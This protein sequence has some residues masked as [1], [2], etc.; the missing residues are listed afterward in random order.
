MDPGA[1]F[2]NSL[3][4]HSIQNNTICQLGRAGSYLP[5]PN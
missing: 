3:H 5:K 4:L 2:I 1:G